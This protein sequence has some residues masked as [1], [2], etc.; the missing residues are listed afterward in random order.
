MWE[1][2]YR[3]FRDKRMNCTCGRRGMNQK[4][5]PYIWENISVVHYSTKY[6]R[7][8]ELIQSPYNPRPT[9][10]KIHV[11]LGHDSMGPVFYT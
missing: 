11:L 1:N 7:F 5:G 10:R 4:E 6:N 3:P 9:I 2:R 8:L